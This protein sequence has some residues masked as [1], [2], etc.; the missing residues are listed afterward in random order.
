MDPREIENV[1]REEIERVRPGVVV[2]Y[3]V[4]GISGFHDHVVSH[5]VVK[6]VYVEMAERAAYLKRLAFFTITEEQAK[7]STY[8]HL[9]GSTDGEIDCVFEVD[10]ADIKNAHR[11]LDCYVTFQETIEKTG[12]KD[13]IGRSAAFEIFREDHT[14]PLV[15]LFEGLK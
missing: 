11:A 8:F 13:R 14:P 1:I 2:T 5:A 7:A 4:H 12:I 6:R 3:A 9:S 10:D 15:D